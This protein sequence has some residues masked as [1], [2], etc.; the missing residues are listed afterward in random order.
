[1]DMSFQRDFEAKINIKIRSR[2]KNNGEFVAQNWSEN[3]ISE[4]LPGFLK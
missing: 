3:V 1:M 2:K 4:R